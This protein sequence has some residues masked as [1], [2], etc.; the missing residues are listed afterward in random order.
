MSVLVALMVAALAQLRVGNTDGF[1][2]FVPDAQTAVEVARPMFRRVMGQGYLD[3]YEP[4]FATKVEGR[5]VV[6]GKQ[7]PARPGEDVSM[8]LYY[9]ALDPWSAR[10]ALFGI[11]GVTKLK[12][13]KKIPL[14]DPRLKKGAPSAH[15][16]P[17][18][19]RALN[20]R[21]AARSP[22]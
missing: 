11:C 20:K 5:W 19:H 14:D 22:A 21:Q 10:V 1:R 18:R 17:Q 7:R 9:M 15:G 8:T 13:L 3:L 6:Q 4:L 12:E 2:G 16:P